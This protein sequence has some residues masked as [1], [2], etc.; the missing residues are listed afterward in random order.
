MILLPV[1]F[2]G[3]LSNE[4]GHLYSV[5]NLGEKDFCIYI[6]TQFFILVVSLSCLV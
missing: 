5:P 4:N 1:I 3:F 2:Q 6:D